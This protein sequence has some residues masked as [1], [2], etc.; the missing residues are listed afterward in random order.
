[1]EFIKCDCNSLKD[2][3][4]LDK[5][6][7]IDCKNMHFNKKL[8]RGLGY[9]EH[10]IFQIYSNDLEIG[11]GGMYKNGFG[12]SLGI[13]RIILL[14]EKTKKY[15]NFYNVV[16]RPQSKIDINI[17]FSTLNKNLDFKISNSLRGYC[18]NIIIEKNK[19]VLRLLSQNK[20]FVFDNI[21]S[22]IEYAKNRK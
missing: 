15:D 19:F 14:L 7:F 11:G 18:N 17:L 5:S 16:I 13:D 8:Y 9:Y 12:W 10:F 3:I 1:M 2:D 6:D 4:E 21:D 20:Q 22:L